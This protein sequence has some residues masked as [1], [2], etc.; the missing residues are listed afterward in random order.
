EQLNTRGKTTHDLLANLFAT[1]KS[2]TD[3]E[4]VNYINYCEMA[5]DRGEDIDAFQLMHDA[6]TR[7]Q[8]QINEGT[9]NVPSK[10]QEKIMAL[11][12]KIQDLT[13]KNKQNNGRNRNTGRGN[14]R[15]STKQSDKTNQNTGNSYETPA[16]KK[17]APKDKDKNKPKKQDGKTYWWCPH[18]K[19]WCVHKA[20]ACRLANTSTNSTNSNNSTNQSSTSTSTPRSESNT[21]NNLRLNAAVSSLYDEE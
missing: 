15:T 12:S 8:N 19:L 18:H 7:Y 2:V 6:Q 3:R 13:K 17:K 4:F 1:F 10:D 9:W 16:W 20:S 21:E 11:E 5:Y 14:Q